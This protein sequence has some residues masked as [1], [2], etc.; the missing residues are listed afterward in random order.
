MPLWCRQL[1]GN[2]G[3]NV[4]CDGGLMYCILRPVRAHSGGLSGSQGQ[5]FRNEL[6]SVYEGHM[7]VSDD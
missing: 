1:G 2:K 3:V 5:Y 6:S 4:L 7:A